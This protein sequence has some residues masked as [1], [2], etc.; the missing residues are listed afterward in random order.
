MLLRLHPEDLTNP[1]DFRKGTW[2]HRLH[3]STFRQE[4]SRS[5]PLWPPLPWPRKPEG[6]YRAS[7]M[8]HTSDTPSIGRKVI[9]AAKS[10]SVTGEIYDVEYCGNLRDMMTLK[11]FVSEP[12]TKEIN[13]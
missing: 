6:G 4:P 2:G 12:P 13:P 10:G 11:V 9:W 8:V 5:V 7:F 3:G 1:I